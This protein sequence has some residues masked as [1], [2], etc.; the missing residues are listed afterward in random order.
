MADDVVA[1]AVVAILGAFVF[2]GVLIYVGVTYG[3]DGLSAQGGYALVGSIG[4]FIL[5]MAVAGYWLSRRS[6]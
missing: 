1:E 4:F 6:A 5:L 2:I 3:D